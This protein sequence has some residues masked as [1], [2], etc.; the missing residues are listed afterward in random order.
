MI[1][2]IMMFV[3]NISYVAVAVIGG[4]LVTRRSIALG[5]VQAFIQYS[6]Q[7]SMPITQL[8]SMANTIQLTIASAER[9]FELLDEP[10]EPAEASPATAVPT[11][12]GEVQIDRMSFSYKPDAPLIEEMSIDVEPGQMVAIVGH[13]GA[14]KTTLVNLLMRFYDVNRGAIR[15]D[16]VDI[17]DLTRGG[18][19]RS[20][21]WCCRTRGCSPARF[22]TTSPTDARTRPR[23][24]SSAPP[25][26]RTPI[27]SSARCPTTTAP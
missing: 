11:L 13:T 14:G 15:V 6:R 27:T 9:V 18:R 4:Y 7:F 12:R 26:P 22:A 20:S 8:S 16:G 24:R 19:G 3:G 25:R 17:R 21:A 5:D 2:P 23:M 10:E 1:F